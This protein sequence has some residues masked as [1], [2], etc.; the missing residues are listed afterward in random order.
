MPWLILVLVLTATPAHAVK[1]PQG[2][3]CEL[4]RSRVAEHGKVI[5]YAWARLNGFSKREINEAGRCL[6]SDKR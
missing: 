1:L 2:V 4:V 5:A 6:I 3:S